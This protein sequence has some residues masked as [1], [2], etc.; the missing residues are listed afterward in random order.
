MSEILKF[1]LERVQRRS[2][3]VPETSHNAKVFLFEGIRYEKDEAK[4]TK[5]KLKKSV[6]K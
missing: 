5:R 6:V 1:P 4:K 2:L 3:G